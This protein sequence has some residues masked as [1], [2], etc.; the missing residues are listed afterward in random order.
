MSKPKRTGK[1]YQRFLVFHFFSFGVVT[2]VGRAVAFFRMGII[3]N[4]FFDVIRIALF[5]LAFRLIMKL[6]G[7]AAK[8]PPEEVSK[9]R[10]DED[11]FHLA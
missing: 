3:F 2:E 1:W 8:L 4:G 6:R 7:A 11:V 5:C 9:E 10:I